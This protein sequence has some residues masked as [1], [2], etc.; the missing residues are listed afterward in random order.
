MPS[1]RHKLALGGILAAAAVSCAAI[2]TT[3]GGAKFEMSLARVVDVQDTN[4]LCSL[5]FRFPIDD[6]NDDSVV[7]MRFH[8]LG[9]RT[10]LLGRERVQCRV[11]GRWLT[12]TDPS[13]LN[14]KYFVAAVAPRS[15]HDFVVAVVPRQTEC[16]RLT[17]E[18]HYESQAERWYNLA[19]FYSSPGYLPKSMASVCGCLR[20][21]VLAPL[22]RWS[23]PARWPK[24][25]Q[26]FTVP[27]SPQRI[28]Q[29]HNE[30]TSADGGWRV[31]F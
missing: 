13:W 22:R 18:Y 11:G 31:L 28:I 21:W 23:F 16:V 4:T 30:V 17:C 1:A 5:D 20:S 2:I 29:Q 9:S 7:I 6:T 14:S 27:A 12:P 24:V 10:L 25:V 8:N 19:G 3:P 15:E 26:E